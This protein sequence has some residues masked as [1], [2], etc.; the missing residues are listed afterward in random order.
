MNLAQ[1]CWGSQA[2]YYKSG[3]LGRVANAGLTD[4]KHFLGNDLGDA[5][6]AI[7]EPKGTQGLPISADKS[8]DLFRLHRRV[9]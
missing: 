2:F 8:A 3:N 9:S 1:I 6:R 4:L 5:V 7:F